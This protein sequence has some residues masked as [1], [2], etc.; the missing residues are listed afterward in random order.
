MDA[1][2]ALPRSTWEELVYR[3]RE[4]DV[5]EGRRAE[6]FA[7]RIVM[8]PLPGHE[9][10]F[11]ASRVHKALVR[12]VPDHWE[13]F[14]TAGLSVPHRHNLVIPDLVVI[15]R[16][17]LPAG[18]DPG[19]VPAEIALLARGVAPDSVRGEDRGSRSGRLRPRHR[20][21]HRGPGV[22]LADSRAV[23]GCRGIRGQP[24]SASRTTGD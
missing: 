13:I 12:A 19:P 21:V 9:H 15:P 1:A 10:A 14:H 7:E 16:D 4:L 23:V 5:P 20:R 18:D 3:W 2:P 24:S 8:T 6:I 11:L 17:R 22:S